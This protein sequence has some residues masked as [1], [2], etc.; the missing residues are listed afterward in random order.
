MQY[1]HSAEAGTGSTAGCTDCQPVPRHTHRQGV[2]G[3]QRVADGKLQGVQQGGQA[4]ARLAA[5]RQQ[6]GERGDNQGRVAGGGLGGG[7]GEVHGEQ[8]GGVVADGAAGGDLHMAGGRQEGRRAGV[9]WK[10]SGHQN[11]MHIHTPNSRTLCHPVSS[12]HRG[13][14]LVGGGQVQHAQGAGGG[15]GG[16]GPLAASHGHDGLAVLKQAVAVAVAPQGAAR[17]V[18]CARGVH[19]S[20]AR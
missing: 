17:E 10:A 18:A 9:K 8:G 6:R 2:S 4:D 13:G 15:G 12:T 1:M 20:R 19:S 3:E 7:K 14:R 5:V 11:H 16:K